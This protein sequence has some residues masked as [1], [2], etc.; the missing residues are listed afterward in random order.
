MA[1]AAGIEDIKDVTL[2]L[3]Y[4]DNNIIVQYVS[5]YVCVMV[6]MFVWSHI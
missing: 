5:M 4:Y 3:I 1:G 6:C 2:V